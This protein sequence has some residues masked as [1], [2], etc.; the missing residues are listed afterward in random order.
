MALARLGESDEVDFQWSPD[1]RRIAF[2]KEGQICVVGAD[3]SGEK[4][5]TGETTLRATDGTAGPVIIDSILWSPS[6]SEI[7]FAVV[8]PSAAR[9]VC[10]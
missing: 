9:G 4:Q 10:S 1:G 6:G 3:G 8:L 5:L 2:I 7:A